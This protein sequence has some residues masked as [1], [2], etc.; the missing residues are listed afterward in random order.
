[1]PVAIYRSPEAAGPLAPAQLPYI[2][3]APS[4]DTVMHKHDTVI[5]IVR[6]DNPLLMR[7]TSGQPMNMGVKRSAAAR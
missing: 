2:F 4:A 7:T 3:T 1:M 6:T 5:V